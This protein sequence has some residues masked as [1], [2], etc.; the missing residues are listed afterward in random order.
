[1][2]QI[3]KIK[4]N[5]GTVLPLTVTD[6]VL[7]PNGISLADVI[8]LDDNG[9]VHIG[10]GRGIYSDSFVSAGGV[11][12]VGGGS[13]QVPAGTSIA[14]VWASLTSNTDAFADLKIDINHIPE[15]VARIEEVPT[16]VSELINDAGYIDD[17]ALIGVMKEGGNGALV[18]NYNTNGLV[19]NGIYQLNNNAN[20]KNNPINGSYGVLA[21]MQGAG[22][23]FAQ[24]AIDYSADCKMFVR[25]GNLRNG[26]VNIARDWRQLLYK[27]D[28]WVSEAE[29]WTIVK[30]SAIVGHSVDDISTGNT[31]SVWGFEP[32]SANIYIGARPGGYNDGDIYITADSGYVYIDKL[33]IGNATLTYDEDRDALVCSLPIIQD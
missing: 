4:K 33:R 6:A 29:N 11:G 1:M 24:I 27:G 19:G 12:P 9:D 30:T 2:A 13:S 32:L 8:T 15:G 28:G 21:M 7:F 18:G 25:A 20:W 26:A 17:G 23:C 22:D 31:Y 14:S 10:G 5:G 3:Y 16:A